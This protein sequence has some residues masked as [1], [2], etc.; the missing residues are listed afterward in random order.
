MLMNKTDEKLFVWLNILT[1]LLLL[2]S[3][4]LIFFCFVFVPKKKKN[5]PLKKIKLSWNQKHRTGK[6]ITAKNR[7]RSVFRNKFRKKKLRWKWN[8]AKKFQMMTIWMM[9]SSHTR[10]KKKRRKEFF[11]VSKKKQKTNKAYEWKKKNS[12]HYS[13]SVVF[14]SIV[15]KNVY[16]KTK[17][18]FIQSISQVCIMVYWC[19]NT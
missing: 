18:E 12:H 17:Q 15:L 10:T 2:K 3:I 1:K 11:C 14:K 8:L 6:K 4:S 9:W 19:W 13:F 7:F 5:F 16:E